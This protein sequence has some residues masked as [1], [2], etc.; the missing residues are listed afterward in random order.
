[1][2]KFLRRF[3]NA[4]AGLV[5]IINKDSNFVVHVICAVIVI[6]M[7]I[8]FNLDTYEWLWII[9]AIFSVL[10]AEILNTSIEYVVDMV[11]KDFHILAKH[12]KDTAAFAV[13]VTSMMALIIGIIIFLPKII[14]IF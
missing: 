6:V 9:V 11:T 5:T 8:I 14:H 7:G 1:M 2:N 3:K 13:F 12:A 4:L 10:T